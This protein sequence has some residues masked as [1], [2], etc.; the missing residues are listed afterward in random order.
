[1]IPMKNHP[2]MSFN[3]AGAE[4]L[5]NPMP[6]AWRFAMVLFMLFGATTLAA[7]QPAGWRS[8]QNGGDLV[9]GAE[10][11]IEWSPESVAWKATLK[12]YGQSTPLV[13]QGQVYVTSTS[14]ENKD[15]CHLAALDL[16]SGE[17]LWSVD[18]K[19]PTPEENTT[20]V[21]R[22]APT[23]VVDAEACYV[24]F[25]GGLV[26]AVSHQG[27]IL[28][29]RD[30]VEDYGSIKARHGLAASL[31]QTEALVFAWVER[32]DSPYVLA[33]EKATGKTAWK[34][35]GLGGTSWSSPRLMEIGRTAQLVCSGSGKIVGF[36]AD[37]G[38]RLWEFDEIAN[39]TS[40]TPIPVAEDRFL[41]GASNGRGQENSG[42]GARS[43]GI[44]K[45][46]EQGDGTWSADFLWSAKRAT[47]SFGSPIVS[48]SSAF[49]VNRAGV[50]YRSDLDSGAESKPERLSCGGI[51]ATPLVAGGKLYLFGQ[52]GVTSIIDLKSGKEIAANP[53]WT[54]GDEAN[55]APDEAT[56]ASSAT[57]LYAGTPAPPFLLLRTGDVLYAVQR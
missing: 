33:I 20:Y 53:L 52:K 25:E 31:E 21:S 26:A 14:G 34:V 13:H 3:A 5:K 16:T 18:F 41:I 36:S 30:L 38:E 45:V 2:A 23:P 8:F 22:A 24:F 19:N 56:P 32:T 50:L 1:M 54:S 44:I 28:W 42:Q 27:R 11:P 51:W 12:G 39:N 49:F 46:T 29:Q 4:A 40:C 57:V 7:K 6:A 37:S 35:P 43:N 9:A 10:L 48:G 47:S 15:S 55:P 17:T